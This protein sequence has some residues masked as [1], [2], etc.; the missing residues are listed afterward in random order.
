MSTKQKGLLFAAA[1]LILTIVSLL[2]DVI[3][4]GQ[5]EGFGLRQTTGAILGIMILAFGIRLL[6]WEPTVSAGPSNSS[7]EEGADFPDAG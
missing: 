6:R 1:G 4:V 3:G 7:E 5:H 2:A